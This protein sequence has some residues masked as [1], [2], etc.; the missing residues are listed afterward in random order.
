V[1]SPGTDWGERRSHPFYERL[2]AAMLARGCRLRRD[3]H[4]REFAFDPAERSC[5]TLVS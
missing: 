5:A 1:A 3:Q 4:L 2:D